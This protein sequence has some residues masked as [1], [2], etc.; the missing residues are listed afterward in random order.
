MTPEQRFDQDRKLRELVSRHA[1]RRLGAPA[2]TDPAPVGL[3]HADEAE[4][5]VLLELADAGRDGDE[6]AAIAR[7]VT[8]LDREPALA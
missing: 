1:A 4:L 5:E 3:S 6:R 8:A 2:A 7:L